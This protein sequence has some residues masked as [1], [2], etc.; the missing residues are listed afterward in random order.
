MCMCCVAIVRFVCPFINACPLTHSS[1]Y[2]I[3]HLAW[4]YTFHQNVLYPTLGII[5]THMHTFA[6]FFLYIIYKHYP[7]SIRKLNFFFSSACVL[8]SCTFDCPTFTPLIKY[9]LRLAENDLIVNHIF[10]KSFEE[11]SC[12]YRTDISPIESGTKRE[13]TSIFSKFQL[14]PNTLGSIGGVFFIY[15]CMGAY[16]CTLCTHKIH[17]YRML[18]TNPNNDTLIIL[19]FFTY[20]HTQLLNAYECLANTMHSRKKNSP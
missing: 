5:H 2:I 19:F 9:E 6:V 12:N 20:T 8:L 11:F 13:I 17:I 3:F 15:E 10:Y 4:Q 1:L 18:S 14:H 16:I 7:Y